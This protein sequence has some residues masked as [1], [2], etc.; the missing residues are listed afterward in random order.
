MHT[1]EYCRPRIAISSFPI[2]FLTGNRAE[3]ALHCKLF[4]EDKVWFYFSV[5]LVSK[6]KK[7]KRKRNDNKGNFHLNIKYLKSNDLS[8]FVVCY[9][10]LVS[11]GPNTLAMNNK[12]I[13]MIM[14]QVNRSHGRLLFSCTWAFTFFDFSKNPADN[15]AAKVW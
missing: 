11:E 4:L 8:F 9:L 3:N 1:A 5:A 2:S 10:P 14:V 12:K 15:S 7:R 6:T 13:I